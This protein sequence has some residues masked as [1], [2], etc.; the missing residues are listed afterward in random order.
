MNST[1]VEIDIITISAMNGLPVE[2]FNKLV[3]SQVLYAN[4]SQIGENMDVHSQP[5]ILI[6]NNLKVQIEFIKPKIYECNEKDRRHILLAK[7]KLLDGWR[8]PC[9]RLGGQ[10]ISTTDT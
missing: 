5:R 3:I 4:L 8:L 2:I 10:S 1:T 6:W 9:N 7:C